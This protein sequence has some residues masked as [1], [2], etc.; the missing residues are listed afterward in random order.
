[1]RPAF[2]CPTLLKRAPISASLLPIGLV[3]TLGFA[4]PVGSTVARLMFLAALQIGDNIVDP[5]ANTVHDVPLTALCRIIEIDLPQAVGEEAP[6]L[7]RL[8]MVYCG[9]RDLVGTESANL[10]SQ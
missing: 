3:E 8:T 9:E 10:I 6:R 4:T 7:S 5:F 2:R 1:M